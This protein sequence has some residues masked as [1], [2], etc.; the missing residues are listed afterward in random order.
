MARNSNVGELF[1][2]SGRKDQVSKACAFRSLC[3]YWHLHNTAKE[4]VPQ[5]LNMLLQVKQSQHS[6]MKNIT[7]NITTINKRMAQHL[8]NV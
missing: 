7:K 2:S 1:E 6:N 3:N 8:L 4:K 5:F